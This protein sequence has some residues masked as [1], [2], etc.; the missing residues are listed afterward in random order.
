MRVAVRAWVCVYERERESES[1]C[2]R[3]VR[4]KEYGQARDERTKSKRKCTS[5]FKCGCASVGVFRCRLMSV[6]GLWLYVQGCVLVCVGVPVK[7]CVC[8]CV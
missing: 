2:E 3:V 8:E 7:M 6:F 5:V 4:E 1:E